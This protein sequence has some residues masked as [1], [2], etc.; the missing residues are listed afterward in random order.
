ML[1]KKSVFAVLL[2]STVLATSTP[3][4]N[5]NYVYKEGTNK[6]ENIVVTNYKKEITNQKKYMNYMVA[7]DESLKQEEI[8]HHKELEVERLEKIKQQQEEEQKKKDT[9]SNNISDSNNSGNS[10][11]DWITVKVSYYTN[12]ASDCQKTD[13]IS[14]SGKNL[15][16]GGNYIA[17]P[18]NIPFGTRLNIQGIGVYEVVDRGGAIIN[19]SNGVMHLDVFVPGASEGELDNMGTHITK[20]RIIK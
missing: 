3:S 11:G 2:S 17:A 1:G 8:E 19:D 7:L 14:A 13:G 5:A 18:G 16:N 20:A 6:E 10:S 12:S 9:E 15:N 4:I